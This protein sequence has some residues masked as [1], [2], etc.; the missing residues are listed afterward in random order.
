M[1]RYGR[2]GEEGPRSDPSIEWASR[3][4]E[5][6]VWRLGL[7]GGG[8]GGGG[9][10]GGEGYPERSNEP[11]CIY[12]LRTGV[13]GYGSR[14]RFN[15]PRDRGA[16]VGGVRGGDGA[17]PE[18]MGQPV[19]QHFMRTGTCKYGA[20]CKYHHPRQG[21]VGSLA[22]VSLSYLGYPLRAGE[23]ECSYYMRTGQCKFGLTC[24]FNHPVPQPQQQ[25]QQQQ[26]QTIYPTIQSQPMPS[27]QQYG[28]VLT[29]PPSL[30][31]GSYLPSPYGPPPMVLP[32]GMVTYPNWN[33]YQ[34][35]LTAMPSPGT[36]TQPSIGSSSVYGGVA[37]LSPS[38]TAYTTGTYQS[39][40]PSLT[41]TSKEQSFPQRPDQPEC[42]YFM[43]TGDC[44]FGASCRYHHPPLDAVQ[45]NTGVLL[46]SIGLP[47]RPGVAQCTHFAQHGIC[48][49]GP[50]CKFDHSMASS[51]SY[52]PSASSLTDM[53]VAPY[54]VGSSSLSG[55]SAPVSSSV[56]TTT[57]EA[58]TAVV[59]SVNSQELAETG[60]DSAGVSGS[61][62]AKTS[63]I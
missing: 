24:R 61:I 34:A 6:S 62:E 30:L 60:G 32:P 28:L 23:K 52:S 22:P 18:R 57:A 54:P 56:E 15:H 8:A 35:S 53:P 45:T 50:A 3:G 58:V 37:P 16:V 4:V 29:R 25:Q 31:S 46:S 13:C 14:C 39:G 26:T 47:L 27:S 40:G 2:A 11:D 41:T 9:G 5:G 51:L 10:G 42:Q 55:A 59:S 20:S 1:E 17:L 43:R 63:S 12:Y 49:F 48:K 19:C 21:G 7:S 36:G 44:K 33:P 38:G